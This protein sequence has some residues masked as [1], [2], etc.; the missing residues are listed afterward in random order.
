[1]LPQ[2]IDF[3]LH[4]DRYLD[5]FIR[6]YGNWTYSLLFFIIFSETGFVIT[7]FLPGDSLLFAAGA[8][9]ARGGLNV[10]VLF[11]LLAL[12]AIAG[13]TSNYFIGR[14]VGPKVFETG[15]RFFKKEYLDR[16]HAFYEK[17]GPI[18]VVLAR[19][20]PIVRTFAPFVA[21]I[22]RMSYSQFLLYNIVGGSLWVAL[23]VLGGYF[24]GNIT[25]VRQNFSLVILAIIFL[26]L[27]P[28]II[29][30]I[31]HR[32]RPSSTRKVA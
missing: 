15:S 4:F 19:F 12:A 2:F 3:V 30:Y 31:R 7:P 14:Y 8:L 11:L 5:T 25:A 13:N 23:F 9:A 32:A 24:F 1:M 18:T 27:L 21:G 22:G 6:T 10:W 29:E 16:A 17:Y 28:A 26:S 20:V